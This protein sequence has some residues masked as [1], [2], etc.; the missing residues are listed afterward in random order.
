MVLITVK[1]HTV[2]LYVE[3]YR[4]TAILSKLKLRDAQQK[5]SSNDIPSSSSRTR[6][7][8]VAVGSF[9]FNEISIL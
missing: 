3:V 6:R 5:A 2:G 7:G 9:S 8:R 4:V 1:V